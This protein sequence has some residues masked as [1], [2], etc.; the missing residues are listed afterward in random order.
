MALVFRVEAEHIVVNLPIINSLQCTL[1]HV[2][3]FVGECNL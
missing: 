2:I 3:P 1:L